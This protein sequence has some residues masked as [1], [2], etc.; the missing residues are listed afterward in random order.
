MSEAQ[1]GIIKGV[2]ELDHVYKKLSQA[3]VDRLA[4]MREQ[5]NLEKENRELREALQRFL[6]VGSVGSI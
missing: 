4:L 6:S 5:S 3:T 1:S 2:E